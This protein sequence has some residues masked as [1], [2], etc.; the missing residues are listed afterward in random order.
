MRV[1]ITNGQRYLLDILQRKLLNTIQA[2]AE[3]S[4]TRSSS[5]GDRECELARLRGKI[6][7]IS[8]RSK[9]FTLSIR[10][11]IPKERFFEALGLVTKETLNK[12]NSKTN[13]R[14]RRTTANPRFSHEAIQAKRA[15]EPA[16]TK[17]G[18]SSR[19]SR[20]KR[21]QPQSS[22][23]QEQKDLMNK[24]LGLQNEIGTKVS[25][26]QEKRHSNRKLQEKLNAM[27]VIQQ[28]ISVEP[29]DISL[30]CNESLDCNS[31]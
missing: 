26:I 25:Q 20:E 29:H 13:Q 24:L 7:R 1:E 17:R 16:Q 2:Y 21:S 6:K 3:L 22:L 18:D 28:N 30:E 10:N 19:V 9:R 8:A 12:L 23:H 31:F 15:L 4:Q 11:T 27:H 5:T 14:R